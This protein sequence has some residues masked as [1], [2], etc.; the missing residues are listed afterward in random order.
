MAEVEAGAVAS[1][2]SFQSLRAVWITP[3][4]PTLHPQFRPG[5]LSLS[6]LHGATFYMLQTMK[7]GRPETQSAAPLKSRRLGCRSS[8]L[9]MSLP[10]KLTM[11]RF[12]S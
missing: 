8:A 7:K 6:G 1:I 10:P 4:G 5:W 9:R 2:P 12:G 11:F 3:T